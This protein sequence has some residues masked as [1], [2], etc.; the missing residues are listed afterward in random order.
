MRYRLILIL[1][2]SITFTSC[3]FFRERGLFLKKEKIPE[4]TV[5]VHDS[6]NVKKDTVKAKPDTVQSA[7]DMIQAEITGAALAKNATTPG[8]RII[9]G[10]FTSK[11]NAAEM[12]GKYI[13]MG[14]N[15]EI[16]KI[17]SRPKSLLVT[18]Y[19]F[20]THEQADQQLVQIKSNVN[21]DA[22]IY[23]GEVTKVPL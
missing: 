17:K 12:A 4:V 11:K 3:H 8:F 22:W 20:G 21:R 10:S 5:P 14:Y 7:E 15:A 13:K 6:L 19:T 23:S 18:I 2:L 16:I 9:V 1:A